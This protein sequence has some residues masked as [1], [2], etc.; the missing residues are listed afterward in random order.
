MSS[1]GRIFEGRDPEEIVLK[2]RDSEFHNRSLDITTYME[3]VRRWCND[4][5]IKTSSPEQFLRSLAEQGYLSI[6]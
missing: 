2:M 1:D 6:K 3:T 5:S 4:E